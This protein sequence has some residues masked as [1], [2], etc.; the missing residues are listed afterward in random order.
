MDITTIDKANEL[1][2]KIREFSE[3]LNCFEWT[4]IENEPPVSLNPRLIIEY[5]N[6]G[7]EQTAIPMNLSNAMVEFLKTEIIKGRDRAVAE[8]NAL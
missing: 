5:D 7:R 8:F 4:P 6:D 3:A 2:Q 1:N